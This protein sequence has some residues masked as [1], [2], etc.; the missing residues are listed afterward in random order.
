MFDSDCQVNGLGVERAAT[1][2][3]ALSA[4]LRDRG[5]EPIDWYGVRLFTDGWAPE[6]PASDPDDLVLRVE[7]EASRRDP[8]RR[9]SRLFH[10]VGRR[11]CVR[12]PA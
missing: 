11:G 2:S 8:Y 7:H 4:L 6:R 3:G 9:M 10:L 1:T 12:A 5:V